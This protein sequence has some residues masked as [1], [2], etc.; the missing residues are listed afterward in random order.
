MIRYVGHETRK[1]VKRNAFSFL[2]ERDSFKDLEVD[3]NIKLLK[4][5]LK[6]KII[7]RGLDSSGSGQGP[8]YRIVKCLAAQYAINIL[9]I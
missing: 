3:E 8:L 5:M 4:E 6:N 2:K 1:G 9:N 7:R